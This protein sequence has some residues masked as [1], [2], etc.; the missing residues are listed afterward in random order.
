[1]LETSLL[2]VLLVPDMVWQNIAGIPQPGPKAHPLQKQG[3]GAEQQPCMFGTLLYLENTFWWSS[4]HTCTQYYL[5][6]VPYN[7]KIPDTA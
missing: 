7:K 1:M 5:C 3:E 2:K 6:S 4:W